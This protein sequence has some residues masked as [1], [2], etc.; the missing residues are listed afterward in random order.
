MSNKCDKCGQSL[1]KYDPKDR[2]S[3]REVEYGKAV[4]ESEWNADDMYEEEE[5]DFGIPRRVYSKLGIQR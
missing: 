5:R 1:W 3:Y 2:K 4:V